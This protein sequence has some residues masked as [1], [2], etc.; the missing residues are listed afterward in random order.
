[1]LLLEWVPNPE[2]TF[3]FSYDD[4]RRST[5]GEHPS[6]MSASAN[7]TISTCRFV[8]AVLHC[9][10]DMVPVGVRKFIEISIYY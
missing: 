8:G 7:A 10:G 6:G 9:D 1:M 2:P 5:A 3:L 4:P